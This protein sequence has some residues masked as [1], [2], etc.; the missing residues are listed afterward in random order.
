MRVSKQMLAPGSAD[1]EAGWGR[2]SVAIRGLPSVDPWVVSPANKPVLTQAGEFPFG[3]RSPARLP[4]PTGRLGL[5]QRGIGALDM[6]RGEGARRGG[7]V[8]RS[9]VR[10]FRALSVPPP[11]PLRAPPRRMAKRKVRQVGPLP[12]RARGKRGSCPSSQQGVWDSD[13]GGLGVARMPW[14][15]NDGGSAPSVPFPCL[16]LCPARE[17]GYRGSEPGRAFLLFRGTGEEGLV[18][19]RSSGTPAAVGEPVAPAPPCSSITAAP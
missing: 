15:R 16:P 14:G 3:P 9:A 10:A 5:R 7:A 4:L 11:C 17:H 6:P 18:P 2:P 12:F 13:N 19:V 8:D 1:D